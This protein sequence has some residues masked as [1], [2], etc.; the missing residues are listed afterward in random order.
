MKK[1]AK[2]IVSLLTWNGAQYLPS[3]L[4][5]LRAQTYKDWELLVLDNA[6]SDDSLKVLEEYRPDTTI[7]RQKQNVGFSR[8]H[9]LIINW[10]DSDYILVLNQDIILEP[11]YLQKTVYFLVHNHRVASVAGKI[12]RWDFAEAKKTDIIDSFG[13]KVGRQ[14]SVS[15]LYQGQPDFSL[16]SQEVFGL[17]G[18]ATLYRRRALETV[19]WPGENNYREYFDDDFFAY[20]EDWDLAWRL[21]L[22]GWQN[23]FLHTTYAYHHRSVAETV[24]SVSGVSQ[25]LALRPQRGFVNRLSYR[26][27]LFTLYKN[28]FFRNI[29]QDFWL[30][31]YMELKK[32]IYLLIF[33]RSTLAG[34][35]EYWQMSRSIK[36]KR[37]FIRKHAKL[38]AEDMRPWFR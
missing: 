8:G 16:D 7:I 32:L 9:N 30:I 26:N 1:Q 22:A 10:S 27:H 15:D 35:K 34:L 29:W 19:A 36:N 21:R 20:K 31:L 38:T 13:L 11:D 12:M 4:L 6:S 23:W 24:D 14:R 17:S 18:M 33:E 5:S 28:S 25:A 2:V 37:R 3:L